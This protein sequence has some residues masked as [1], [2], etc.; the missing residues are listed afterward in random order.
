MDDELRKR[1]DAWGTDPGPE[2]DPVFAQ[3]LEADLRS[4]AYFT[5]TPPPP[6]S[7]RHPLLRPGLVLG[8]LVLAALAAVVV[9][10]GRDHP[11]EVLVIEDTAGATVTLPGD[12]AMA[13]VD[14]TEL[15]DGTIIDVSPEGFV[16]VGGIVLPPDSRARIVDGV[17]ELIEVAVVPTP[18]PTPPATADPTATATATPEATTEAP[19]APVTPTP[20]P[21]PAAPQPTPTAEPEI[22]ATPTAAPD[23]TA[24]APP[25]PTPE[26]RPTATPTAEPS[27]TPA[28]APEVTLER[29]NLGPQRSR[30]T[31]AV[32]NPDD[33]RGF[34]VRIRRGDTVRTAAVLRRPNVREL[35]VE[36]PERDRVFYR[37]LAIGD[38]GE[39]LATSNEVRVTNGDVGPEPTPTPEGGG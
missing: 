39:V 2:V 12:T 22:R 20:D 28:L 36:R 16:V 9:V 38:G 6:S 5:P 37:V 1:L 35:V 29:S 19:P 31:W 4:A 3:R 24:T 30:L 21:T 18:T 13:A 17:V 14:G 32:T 34:E 25:E 15:P 27:P 26:P 33:I 7:R 8:A 23:P 11:T 10:A